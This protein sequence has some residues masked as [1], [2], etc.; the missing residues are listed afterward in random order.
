MNANTGSIYSSMVSPF[1]AFTHGLTHRMGGYL[2]VGDSFTNYIYLFNATNGSIYSSFTAGHYMTGGL[3]LQGGAGGSSP[4]AL[5]SSE[6]FAPLVYRQNYTNGSIYSSFPPN[7]AVFD[8]AW[9]YNNNLIW[10][11]YSSRIYGYDTSGSL[12]ASF[13]APAY[14]PGGMC[15]LG[16]YLWIGT[17]S[18]SHRIWKVHCPGNITVE[19]TSFGKVKAL[20][21]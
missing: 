18:G 12:V 7:P 17:S 11:G 5:F 21:R 15:Y 4:Q 8:L 16:H 20:F 14:T 9:D 2:Y 19:P 10:G 3:A 1:G 6:S 13:L